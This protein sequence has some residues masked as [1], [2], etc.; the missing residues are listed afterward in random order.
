MPPRL[1]AYLEAVAA[2]LIEIAT[3]HGTRAFRPALALD[4]PAQ[5]TAELVREIVDAHRPDR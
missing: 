5:T 4:T 3:T 2:A 1:A